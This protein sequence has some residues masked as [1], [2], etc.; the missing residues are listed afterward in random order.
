[1]ILLI[2]TIF[3]SKWQLL[4]AA[5]AT[6]LLGMQA[7]VV[8]LYVLLLFDM[9]TGILAAR[10]KGVKITSKRMRL[11][12]WK[13]LLYPI[14]IGCALT[15]DTFLISSLTVPI[16]FNIVIGLVGLTEFKSLAE[17]VSV[18]LEYDLWEKIKKVFNR[19]SGNDEDL[20][21]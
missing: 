11:G 10:K 1:M 5:A 14:F 9:I 21:D 2:Y 20:L 12:L 15:L 7:A 3:T 4:V 17:N 19:R 6:V 13:F 8:A 18:M 16:M